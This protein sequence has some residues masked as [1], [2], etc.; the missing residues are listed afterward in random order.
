[1][2]GSTTKRRITAALGGAIAA[3]ALASPASA[4]AATRVVDIRDACDEV[5]FAAAGLECDRVDSSG[6][7]VTPHEFGAELVR[8]GRHDA[9]R[10]APSDTTIRAGDTLTAR[11]SRGGEV[12]TFT[13]LPA[14]GPGCI[15]VIN[16]LVFGDPA[17][18]PICADP[19]AFLSTLVIPG[20]SRSI[21]GLTRGEH[22]FQCL[23]HPWMRTEI[24]VR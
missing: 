16:L 6:K 1:M 13:E 7:G 20:Q 15:D 19:Q 17:T 4:V 14:F 21:S 5:S 2:L 3:A 18:N 22:R 12:H 11:M 8:N 10:F 23:I 24:T 9:W